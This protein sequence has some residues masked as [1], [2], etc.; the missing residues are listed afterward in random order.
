M[1]QV[2][3]KIPAGMSFDL[4]FTAYV[5]NV[6]PEKAETHIIRH[7]RSLCERSVHITRNLDILDMVRKALGRRDVIVTRFFL[8]HYAPEWLEIK[9]LDDETLMDFCLFGVQTRRGF[10]RIPMLEEKGFTL[11][12]NTRGFKTYV[13]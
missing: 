7:V 11:A 6:V 5:L 10:Q 12:A 13:D 3:E 2:A 1:G 8:D 9:D 4:G